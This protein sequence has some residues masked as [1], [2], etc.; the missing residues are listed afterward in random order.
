MT[1]G[2]YLATLDRYVAAAR[3]DP[4][5]DAT[6]AIAAALVEAPRIV[7][8]RPCA[9][10]DAVTSAAIAAEARAWGAMEREAEAECAIEEGGRK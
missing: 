2:T 1:A 7:L 5:I 9:D 8:T 3:L 4:D 6:L 10:T